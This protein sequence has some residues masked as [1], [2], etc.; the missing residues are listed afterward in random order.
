VHPDNEWSARLWWAVPASVVLVLIF[1]VMVFGPNPQPLKHGT[2]YDASPE[3]FRAA[4]LLLD[5]LG[6]PV[7]R[8]KRPAGGAV[9][10]VLFPTAAAKEA[11]EQLS[12]WVQAGGIVVLADATGEFARQQGWQLASDK[13][14]AT[15][16]EEAASGPGV[17]RLAGGMVRVRWAGQAGRVWATV[18]DKP[19][20]TIHSWGR[21]EVWLVNR[22]EFLT[23]RLLGQADNAVLLC[24]LA[25]A[26]L[27]QRNGQLVFDEYCHGLRER[28]GVTELLLQ[29]PMLWVTLQG[30]LL[31]GL[32]L[33]HAV[34]RFGALRP[35]PPP[36]R[37][38]KEEFLHSLAAL[39]EHKG[40]YADAL[41]TAR[42]DF[43]HALERDLGLPA[44]TPS[45]QLLEEATRRR[46]IRREMLQPLL[47]RPAPP[48]RT[49]AAFVQ[50]LQSLE[51]ARD[52][53]F[54][55]RHHR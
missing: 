52:E 46:P 31:L 47:A 22:P 24:R 18:G 9:R 17:T 11:E 27:Q 4:Y 16:T 21:G 42:A 54:H 7:A 30:L 38:S 55:G 36:S 19:L 44:G 23:N 45:E 50:A 1:L 13:S 3:G 41:A 15:A 2:S 8:S 37:R 29:P 5:E 25:D 49:A 35:V 33:W 12:P 14:E 28:P 53:F 20:V 43:V 32:L 26:V 48:A 10:W 34:P 39:L 40:D 51:T 6:Y